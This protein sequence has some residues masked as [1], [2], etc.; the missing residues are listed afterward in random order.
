MPTAPAVVLGR[1][2]DGAVIDSAAAA[3]LNWQVL[4][5]PTPG[6]VA[7]VDASAVCVEVTVP[8]SHAQ[9]RADVWLATQWFGELMV[10]ALRSVGIA[11]EVAAGSGSPVEGLAATAC[12]GSW[13]RGEVLAGGRKV[14]GVAQFR[15]QGHALLQGLALTAGRHGGIASALAGPAAERERAVA[16][17]DE[18][19]AVLSGV[20]A[21][22]VRESLCAVLEHAGLP[23]AAT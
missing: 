8:A 2:Q 13:V 22:T 10:A 1:H 23:T 5:R 14:F 7:Y 17:I 18:R 12:F 6:G 9:A 21:E 15:R 3:D 19:S 4:R 20:S 11:A 16:V